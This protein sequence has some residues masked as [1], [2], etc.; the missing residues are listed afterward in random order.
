MNFNYDAIHGQKVTAFFGRNRRSG[1]DGKFSCEEVAICHP[2]SVATISVTA[3]TDEIVLRLCEDITSLTSGKPGWAALSQFDEYV[4]AE[5]GWCWMGKN[6]LGYE[7]TIVF[8]FAG[9]EPQIA[10]CGVASFLWFYRMQRV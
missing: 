3:N 1:D 5:L 4:G 6:Y 7:D 10:I 9:V 8:S 2:N